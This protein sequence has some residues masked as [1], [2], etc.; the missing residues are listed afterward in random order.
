MWYESESERDTHTQSKRG[1]KSSACE[2]LHISMPKN[3]DE[4][5]VILNLYINDEAKFI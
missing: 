4:D 1:G 5:G 2:D 3:K